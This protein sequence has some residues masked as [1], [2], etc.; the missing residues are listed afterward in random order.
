[1][2]YDEAR[3]SVR[4]EL[5]GRRLADVE[6]WPTDLEL[7]EWD[8][9]ELRRRIAGAPRSAQFRRRLGDTRGA[10]TDRLPQPL[11]RKGRGQLESA[12]TTTI[13]EILTRELSEFFAVN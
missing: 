7:K 10:V 8:E 1:M 3:D 4:S 2:D 9:D 12:S 6:T 13:V 5:A 11:S